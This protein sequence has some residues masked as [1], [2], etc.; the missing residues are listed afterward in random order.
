MEEL[1]FAGILLLLQ[2][3]PGPDQAF[4]HQKHAGV[5]I[6]SRGDGRP[7]HRHGRCSACRAGV[8][9]GGFRFS[10]SAGAGA[11]LP[12][13]LLDAVSGLENMARGGKSPVPA[14][15]NIPRPP[16]FYRDALLTNLMNPKATFFFVALAAPLL[17]KKSFRLLC[18]LH[19]RAHRGYGY[20]GMDPLGTRIPLASHPDFL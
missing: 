18:L 17:E 16:P 13:F 4:R 9:G 14:D 8:H 2:A 10:Q 7:G 15:G 20:G 6:R 3:S 5:R 11:F 19:R 1:I 12:G